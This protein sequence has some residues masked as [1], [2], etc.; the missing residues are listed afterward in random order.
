MN[1]CRDIWIRRYPSEP[2]ENELDSDDNSALCVTN[3]DILTQVL[4]LRNLYAKLAEPYMS[5]TVYLIAAKQRYK[6]YLSMMLRFA[7]HGCARLVPAS[8]ILLMWLTHQVGVFSNLLLSIV[9]H[10][11]T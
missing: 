9:F 7:D 1:R 3:E 5:E 11:V 10:I 8:D 4:K 2:F 6:S